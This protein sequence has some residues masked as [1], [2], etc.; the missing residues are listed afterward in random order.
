MNLSNSRIPLAI[1]L[2]SAVA[3]TAACT[4]DVDTGARQTADER[5]GQTTQPVDTQTDP[6]YADAARD[7]GPVMGDVGSGSDQPGSDTWI[8]T[9]VKTSLL[10]DTDVAGL[11]INVDTVNGVVT[12]S[13]QVDQQAQIEHAARIAR[14]IEGVTEVQTT[15]LVVDTN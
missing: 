10:A 1:A 9:K 3:L 7:P 13:G 6:G 8:T 12:L 4:Q 5:A 11:D 15:R 14:D 2:G